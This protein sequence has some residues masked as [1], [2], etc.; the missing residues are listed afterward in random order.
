[1]AGTAIGRPDRHRVGGG[2]DGLRGRWSRDR[3]DEC[4][5]GAGAS[6]AAFSFDLYTHCGVRDA[7]INSK[8]F[9]VV[10]HDGNAVSLDDW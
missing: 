5:C 10:D 3:G 8:Y 2:L 4:V 1:V 9:V 7:I 6:A